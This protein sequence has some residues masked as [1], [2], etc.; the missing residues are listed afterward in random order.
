MQLKIKKFD[1]SKIKD[2]HSVAIIGK[3]ACGKSILAKDI[4][5]HKQDIPVCAV[6]DPYY[7]SGFYEKFIPKM[8]IYK[9][10]DPQIIKNFIKRQKT[11]SRINQIDDK[12]SHLILDNCDRNLDE[13][14][15]KLLF[16]HRNYNIGVCFTMQYSHYMPPSI[17]NNID[18]TFIFRENMLPTRKKLYEQHYTKIFESFEQ[19][20]AIMD[21]LGDY[22]CIVIDNT[23]Y[24]GKIEDKIFWYK[25]ELHEDF[26]VGTP[27]L[28]EQNCTEENVDLVEEQSSEVWHYNE[29]YED[30]YNYIVNRILGV[31]RMIPCF[32]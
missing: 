12:R 24:E 23:V 15:H 19:F 13:N 8:L 3:R 27:E 21:G 9:E 28:W 4:I 31:I 14:F 26:H 7:F 2:N 16:T 30:S 17:R 10:Y 18:Y 22:E 29:M 6:I 25:A 32:G 5:Y 20:S 11:I 1:I